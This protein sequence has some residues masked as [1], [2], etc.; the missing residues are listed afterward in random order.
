MRGSLT[1]GRVHGIPVRAHFTLL[2]IIP[3]LGYVMSAQFVQVAKQ[4]G[5][6]PAA[7]TIPP[8]AWGLLLAVLLFAC[9]LAHELGHSLVALHFGGK[10]AS[11]TL[12]LLGGVSELKGMPKK[13]GREA[14]IAAMGPL[15]SLVIGLGALGLYRLVPGP[16]DLRFGL[17]YLGEMNVVLALFNILPAFPMDGGRVLRALLATRMSRVQATRWA[18]WAGMAFA[19]L[20]VVAGLGGGNIV[21][22][23]IGVFIWAGAAAERDQVVREDAVT[24]LKVRDVMSPVHEAVDGWLPATHAAWR[25]AEAHLTALPVAEGGQL[26]GVVALHHLEALKPADRDHTPTSAVTARDVPRLQADELLTDALEEMADH[27]SSEAPVLDGD[28]LVGVLEPNDLARALR[29]RRLAREAVPKRTVVVGQPG[30]EEP[31]GPDS[32]HRE[33]TTPPR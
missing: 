29:L 28:E 23:L 15:V 2:L 9:V 19:A 21:L 12:M 8:Y 27:E 16:A 1:L 26:V 10:V 32:W 7:M 5:V 25:L 20:F 13:P 3:Y 11:I 30:L 33:D 31:S 22:A 14:L 6:S 17:F 4:A 18:A 24:G